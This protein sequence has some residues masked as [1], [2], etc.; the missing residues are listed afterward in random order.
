ML[1]LLGVFKEYVWWSIA[2]WLLLFV[3][4]ATWFAR[5]DM[6]SFSVGLGRVLLSVFTSP[7]VFIRKAAASVLGFTP[8]EEQSYRASN[9]YLLNKAMLVLQAV[10]I[11]L[12]ISALAAGVVVTWNAWVPPSAVRRDAHEYDKRVDAQRKTAT[13]AEQDFQK[14]ESEWSVKQE[15]V[16]AAYRAERQKQIVTA[17]RG[18]RE[19]ERRYNEATQQSSTLESVKRSVGRSTPSSSEEYANVYERVNRDIGW[20]W[21]S[22]YERTLLRQ[23]VAAWYSKSVS[24]HLLANTP[25]L[26]LRTVEQP[27][28]PAAAALRESSAQTLAEMEEVLRQKEEAASLKWTA[29]FFAAAGAFMTF[30]VFVWVAGMI[31]EIAWLAIRVAD[32]VRK[33][34]GRDAATQPDAVMPAPPLLPLL[35]TSAAVPAAPPRA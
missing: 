27:G 23:W 11:L 4:F 5:G 25:V 16:L 22:D 17:T 12:A 10:V 8:Q 2:L 7:F 15:A 19:A 30:L 18:L 26:E 33:I 31:I 32:D 13:N 1:E 29:A 24:E 21:I 34:R 35:D 14:L 6:R 3:A 9:Q 20:M 28:Y